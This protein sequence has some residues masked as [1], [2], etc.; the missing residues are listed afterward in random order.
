MNRPYQSWYDRP[1]KPKI[2]A[3]TNQAMLQ[4]GKRISAEPAK[5]DFGVLLGQYIAAGTKPVP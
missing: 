2:D 1:E 5:N 3:Q 4:A